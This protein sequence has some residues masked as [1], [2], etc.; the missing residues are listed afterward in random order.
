MLNIKQVSICL[1]ALS[2]TLLGQFPNFE[3]TEIATLKESSLGQSSLV[4]LDNDNDLDYIIGAGAGTIWWFEYLGDNKWKEHP[5]GTDALT[6]R[7]GVAIDIDNDGDIDQISGG[8]F[9]ENTGS[10]TSPTFTRHEI[11]AIYAY[12][13]IAV[14]LNNDNLPELISLSEQ[15]GLMLYY[16]NPK[17]GKKWKKIEIDEGIAGGIWP[18][19]YGDIDGDGDLDIVRSN[20]WYE[21]EDGLGKEW[22]PHKTIRFPLSQGKYPYSTRTHVLDMDGDG[23]MD[24]VQAQGHAPSGS[25]AWIENKDGRGIT[26]YQHPIGTETQQELHSLCVADFDNDGDMDVF[27]GGGPKTEE[28]YKRCFIYENVAGKSSDKWK[29]HEILFKVENIDPVAGDVDGDGDI[30]ICSKGWKNKTCFFLE[31]KLID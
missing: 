12:D 14:D 13:N 29:K 31:N 24:V 4:D 22:K 11:G 19:G 17:K 1:L 28:L 23:D 30:D 2:T 8:T 16:Y 9:Y 10:K 21:N 18:K 7:G 5:L 3:Y 27:T 6:D 26:W 15:D 25:V 20:I